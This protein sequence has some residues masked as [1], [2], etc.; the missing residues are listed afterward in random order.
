[1]KAISV[2]SDSI[3][4]PIEECFGKTKYFCIIKSDMDIEYVFNPG[5]DLHKGSGITA[6]DFLFEKGV[7][8]VISGNYGITAKKKLDDHKIQIVIIPP[9]YRKLEELL[10]LMKTDSV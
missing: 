8:T 9:R 3:D 7:K 2:K 10:K 6:V 5:Y 1:M 4:S